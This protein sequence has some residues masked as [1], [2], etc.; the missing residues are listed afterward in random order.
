MQPFYSLDSFPF[1]AIPFFLLAG[2]LMQDAGISQRIFEFINFIIGRVR[3]GLGATAVLACMFFGALTGSSVA[4][5]SAMGSLIIPEMEKQGYTKAYGTALICSS[6]FLGILIPPSIPGIL[7]GMMAGLSIAKVFLAT[8]GSGILLGAAYMLVNFIA[9]GRKQ[10]KTSRGLTLPAFALELIR[11]TKRSFFALLMPIIILGG[12]YGGFFTPTEAAAVAVVYGLVVG[13]LVYRTI[14]IRNLYYIFQNSAVSSAVLLIILALAASTAGRAFTLLQIP[15]TVADWF[16]GFTKS[17]LMVLLLLNVFFIFL[18]MFI[19]CNTLILIFTPVLMT[20]IQKYG[21]DPYHFGAIFL[22]NV[23]IGLITPPFA[24]NLFVGCMITGLT[25]DQI[26]KPMLFF[27]LVC[28]PVLLL[29]TLFPQISLF[30][31]DLIMG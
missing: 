23:E 13:L 16:I 11:S 14:N 10:P 27:L 24:G 29:V 31:P 8:V 3:G 26:W 21:I 2:R 5:V 20:L 22:L 6:G 25:I 28:F 9:F 7:Y 17:P 12:I 19:D 15:D 18:G 4:T 1:M 30:I